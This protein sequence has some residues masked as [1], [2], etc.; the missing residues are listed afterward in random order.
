M[1]TDP[2]IGRHLNIKPTPVIDSPAGP[3]IGTTDEETGVQKF[4]GIPYAHPPIG[5]LRWLPPQA[6]ATWKV[7][8]HADCFGSPA[9]QNSSTLME[10]RDQDGNLPDTE[11]C[12]YLNI[13]SPPI[14]QEKKLPVMFW[15]HGG[16]FYMGS[17]CQN[18]YNGSHLAASGRVIVITINYRLGVLGFLRLK[19]ISDVPSTGNEGLLDQIA[20][21]KWVQQNISAFGGDPS[22]ITLFG[23]SAGA[24]S[25]ASLLEVPQCR[26]II[27]RAIVQSGHP[28]AIHSQQQANHVA[29]TFLKHFAEI[30][31][32]CSLRNCSPK[33]LL[34]VQQ[35]ILSDTLMVPKWGQ[36][37]FKPVADENLSLSD[38]KINAPS[39][40]PL[41]LGNNLEEWNLFSAINPE[42]FSLDYRQICTHLEWLIPESDLKPLLSH[43][44]QLAKTMTG[45][46]WPEWSR[47]WNL[48]L[49][50]MVFTL[51][52]LRHLKDHRGNNFHYHFAQP[53]AA[54]PLLGACHA[55]EL[56]YVFGTHGDQSLQVLYGGEENPHLLSA[57]MQE[58]W[59]S[60]AESGKPSGD[61]PEFSGKYS[62]RFGGH[63]SARKFNTPELLSL[64][65]HIPDNA[66]NGYL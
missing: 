35:K 39:N 44:Y 43:Y 24:M 45:N 18:I 50:D 30:S 5:K 7:P 14:S 31:N 4:L 60:F 9:A 26:G 15:I 46:P 12:L 53:L 34:K 57:S 21:L 41:L 29:K 32:G 16:S 61:W 1:T 58:A 48:L 22:N 28:K 40:T 36:L 19:D 59:L 52:G 13:F 6:L 25:I 37:P 33:L 20:A 11:E 8:L 23:E 47:A 54:Q 51:P 17:G 2:G 65:Q 64:W 27:R 55:V 42:S 66:L 62:K 3:I 56:G 38:V 10:V 49:T 63:P